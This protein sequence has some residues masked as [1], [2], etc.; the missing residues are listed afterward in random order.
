MKVARLL[1]MIGRPEDMH[2]IMDAER[3]ATLAYLDKVTRQMGGQRGQPA[4]SAQTQDCKKCVVDSPHLL[5]SE[6]PG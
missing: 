3:D 1:G 2:R 4:R 6:V 5:R